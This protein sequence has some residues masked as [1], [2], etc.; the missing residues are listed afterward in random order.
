MLPLVVACGDDGS[1]RSCTWGVDELLVANDLP[2]EKRANCGE[3]SYADEQAV[4]DGLVCLQT[5]RDAKK[6]AQLTVNDCADCS[7]PNTFITTR[8]GDLFWIELEADEYGDEFFTATLARC[9]EF[10]EGEEGVPVC[11]DAEEVYRCQDER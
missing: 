9:A 10:V 4:A 5:A 6:A 2:N 7:I 11:G 8:A 1:G 3:F